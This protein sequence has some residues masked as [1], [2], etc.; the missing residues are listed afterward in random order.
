MA[1][2]P[3]QL[4][5]AYFGEQ[6]PQLSILHGDTHVPSPAQCLCW[7][8]THNTA[9]GRGTIKATSPQLSTSMGLH[10]RMMCCLAALFVA[11]Y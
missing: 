5:G 9:T 1:M 8:R 3:A 7:R 2:N 10:L 11:F 4:L 6:Q